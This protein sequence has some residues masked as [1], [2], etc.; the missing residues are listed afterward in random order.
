MKKFGALIVCI[1][2]CVAAVA[3]AEGVWVDETWREVKRQVDCDGLPLV[4]DARVLQVAEDAMG[5]EYHTQALSNAWMEEKMK[6]VDWSQLGCDTS[7]GSWRQP[8]NDWPEYKYI[9]GESIFPT[10]GV[11]AGNRFLFQK[12]D[13]EYAYWLSGAYPEQVDL[14]PIG[15]LTEAEIRKWAEK[16]AAICGNQLGEPIAVFRGDQVEDIRASMERRLE[17]EGLRYAL[18]PADAE[19]Y[20][21]MDVLFPVYFQGLRLYSGEYQGTEDGLEIVNLNMRIMVTRDH[22]I[23]QADS[24]LFDPATFLPSTEPQRLLCAEE[25]LKRICDHYASMY[26]PGVKQVTIHQLALEYVAITGDMSGSRG[27]TVYPTWVAKYTIESESGESIT[28]TQGVHAL[29]GEM[30]F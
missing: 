5:Q 27:Y 23:I 6:A 16:I 2:F 29:T 20:L 28:T 17:Q 21:F 8:T 26:L 3:A 19:E 14:S 9:N 4:I 18:D 24:V 10:F 22:G 1:C 11:L 7:S 25:A 15:T 12:C 30:L 13:C